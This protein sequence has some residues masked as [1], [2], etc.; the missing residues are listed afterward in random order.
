M[1]ALFTPERKKIIFFDMNQTLVDE[2]GT[3]DDSFA[4]ALRDYIGR[5]ETGGEMPD[6][7][8][9]PAVYR[10]EWANTAKKK[11][12]LKSR[13][14]HCLARAL[15]P[16]PL[17]ATEAF[18]QQFFAKIE[19]LK[20]ANF[21]LFAGAEETLQKLAKAYRLA[22]ISNSTRQLLDTQLQVLRL[23]PYFPVKHR[24]CGFNK[25]MRKP[26]PG[27]FLA[28]LKKSGVSAHQAVMVGDSWK[29]DIYGATRCGI[30]AVWLNPKHRDKI[31]QR[32]IGKEKLVI[33]RNIRQLLA[34]FRH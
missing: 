6:L 3:F 30:D 28:A 27:I 10:A 25:A 24:F 21:K 1:K 20:K 19:Q 32:K 26:N 4:A 2:Q 11:M 34:I 31:V 7:K 13:R 14:L 23:E 5:W 33:I 15:K 16:Y 8:H 18:A 12:P 29:N 9:A 17:P 22:V